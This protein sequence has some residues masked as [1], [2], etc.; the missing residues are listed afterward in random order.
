MS[1]TRTSILAAAWFGLLIGLSDVAAKGAQKFGTG[2]FFDAQEAVRR[3]GIGPVLYVSRDIVW[4][5]PLAGLAL[6]LILAPI[7]VFVAH[8]LFRRDALPF[9]VL[10]FTFLGAL[11]LFYMYPRLQEYAALLLAAGI[12]AQMFRLASSRGKAVTRIIERTAWGLAAVAVLLTVVVSGFRFVKEQSSLRVLPVPQREAPNV[13]LIVLDTV[14]TSNLS[15]YGYERDTTPNLKR[16]AENGVVFDRALATAP[17]TLPSHASMFTGRYGYDLSTDWKV[18]L[19]DRYPTLAEQ[20]TKN[21]YLTAGFVANATY[22]SYEHGLDRGFIH[23]EDY[24]V[25]LGQ[26]ISSLT[27][28]RTIANRSSVRSLVKND[29]ELNRQSA[30]EINQRFL[31]WLGQRGNRPFF[32]FL[33]YFDAHDPYFPP[34]PFDRKFGPGRKNPKWSPLLRSGWDE[35]HK[36]MITDAE[37]QEEIDAYDGA[38][39]Y[40]DEQLGKLFDSLRREGVLDN[41]IVVITGDHGEEFGEHGLYS[42]GNSLYLPSVHVPLVVVWPKEVPGGRRVAEPVTLRDL[43]ATMAEM[44]RLSFSFPGKSLARFWSDRDDGNPESPLLSEVKHV[45]GRPAWLPVSKGD[46]RSLVAAGFRYIRNGDGSEELY[47]FNDDPLERSNLAKQ[48]EGLAVL[49]SLRKQLDS[50]SRTRPPGS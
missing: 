20:F 29:E 48:P 16:L 10:V 3:L 7:V 32:V 43:P 9:I 41:T 49:E 25:S 31:R 47:N 38:V 2:V 39:A 6:S 14:G 19:D 23:Y 37:F 4:M 5:A 35:N 45:T 11:N 17:W 13:L 30:E 22:C 40:L 33:N 21:G 1:H 15:V 36:R 50:L 46:M 44:S 28:L 42:H 26:F 8:R 12:A 18:P 27:V 24:P 34:P